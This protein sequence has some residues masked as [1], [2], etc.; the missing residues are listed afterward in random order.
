MAQTIVLLVGGAS[1][2]LTLVNELN[3]V[4][5]FEELTGPL[6]GRLKLT[7]STRDSGAERKAIR[8]TLKLDY[9][10]VVDCSSGTCGALPEVRYTELWSN[11][12]V[13]VKAGSEAHR[14]G[15]YDLQTA[16]IATSEVE[17]LVVKNVRL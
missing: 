1:R 12:I 16:L 9:A 17:N 10:E 8:H 2:T 6:V 3:G 4:R 5:T 14:Q 7:T 11:D 15:L 13:V